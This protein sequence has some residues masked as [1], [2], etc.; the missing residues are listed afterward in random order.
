MTTSIM[1]ATPAYGG[2]VE[3]EYMMAVIRSLREL[4]GQYSIDVQMLK[5]ESLITRARCTMFSWFLESERDVLLFI[6]ADVVFQPHHIQRLVDTPYDVAALSYPKKE[7]YWN[8]LVG[9]TPRSAWDAYRMSHGATVVLPSDYQDRIGEDGFAPATYLSTGFMKITRSAAL[10]MQEAYRDLDYLA[11][12]G[13]THSGVFNT[14]IT[15]EAMLGEDYS[16]CKRW[17]DIGGDL[18]CGITGDPLWHRGAYS[19]VFEN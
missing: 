5:G 11:A 15:P 10:R 19:D 13:S 3:V 2:N 17:T 7:T 9:Q 1:L 8:N 16:F 12:D 6:D 4:D 14:I 18:Y